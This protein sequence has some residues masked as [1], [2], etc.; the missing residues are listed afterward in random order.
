MLDQTIT[1]RN[2]NGCAAQDRADR[3]QEQ[4]EDE[5][6]ESSVYAITED[7]PDMPKDVRVVWELGK[8]AVKDWWVERRL[9]GRE[10]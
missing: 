9:E 5:F 4:V 10:Y 7:H 3:I 6:E 1:R 2:P 8:A